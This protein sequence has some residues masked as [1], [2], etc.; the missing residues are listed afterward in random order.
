MAEHNELGKWGEQMAEKYLVDHGFY[1]RE[2]DWHYDRFDIDIIAISE[3][4]NMLLFIEVKTRASNEV[5]DPLLAIN[6]KKMRSIGIAANAYIKQNQ[7]DYEVRFD[8]LT[9]VGTNAATARID[10]IEDAFNPLLL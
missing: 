2:R 6:R 3:E 5:A 8:V 9:I 10:Y 4:Q 7:L 1:I